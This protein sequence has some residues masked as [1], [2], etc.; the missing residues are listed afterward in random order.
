MPNRIKEWVPCSEAACEAL[1]LIAV[2]DFRP[3]CHL[4]LVMDDESGLAVGYLAA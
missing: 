3:G 1:R 4:D 2:E